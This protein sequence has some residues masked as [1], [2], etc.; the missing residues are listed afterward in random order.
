[1]PVLCS[2]EPGHEGEV[3]ENTAGATAAPLPVIKTKAQVQAELDAANE[4]IAMLEKMLADASIE[5]PP[6]PNAPKAAAEE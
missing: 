6:N 5:F 3:V 4:R 1:M 2:L